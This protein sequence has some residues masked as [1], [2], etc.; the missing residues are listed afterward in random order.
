MNPLEGFEVLLKNNILAAPVWD[1]ETKS[2]TGFL[3]VRDL[4]ASIVQAI[5][6]S[7]QKPSSLL[8][9]AVTKLGKDIEAPSLSYLSRRNPFKPVQESSTL[10]QVA[11]MIKTRNVHRVPVVDENGKCTRIISQSQLVQFLQT[12]K[13]AIES[14]L[15]QTVD[16]TNLGAREVLA[17]AST[18]PALKA[19]QAIDKT[20]FSGLAVVDS[21]GKIIGNTSARDIKYF[22]LNKGE[23]SLDMPV[24]EYLAQVRQRV[25]TASD[26]APVCTVRKDASLG[27]VLGLLSATQYHRLFVVDSKGLP[28][29][30]ISISDLLNFSVYDFSSSTTSDSPSTTPRSLTPRML[31]RTST[32]NSPSTSSTTL[33]TQSHST[34]SHSTH[35]TASPTTNN[36]PTSTTTPTTTGETT[37]STTT[38]IKE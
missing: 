21:H 30:V 26:K 33:S 10:A 11:S 18:E 1:K 6:Q 38:T 37:T 29:G 32:S 7:K 2:Y 27:R 34:P 8:T 22:V 16:G 19:F 13:N 35:T 9:L 17:V 3:D 20:S 23:L 31:P 28:E 4:V 15:N 25:I 14:D 24:L 36:T 5:Q 12:N